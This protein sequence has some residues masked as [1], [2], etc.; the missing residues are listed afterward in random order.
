MSNTLFKAVVSVTR[1]DPALR[2]VVLMGFGAVLAVVGVWF[3]LRLV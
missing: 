2:P 3:G 1:G